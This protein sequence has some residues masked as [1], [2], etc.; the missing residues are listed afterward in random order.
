MVIFVNFNIQELFHKKFV[1]I[2]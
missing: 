1:S 2:G